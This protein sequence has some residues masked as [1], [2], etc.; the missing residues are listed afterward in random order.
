MVSWASASA[1]EDGDHVVAVEGIVDFLAKTGANFR[2]V[3][4]ADGFQQHFLEAVAFKD[5]AK[6]VEHLALERLAHDSKFFEQAEIDITLAGF[7]GDEIPEVADLLLAD[8]VDAT[9]ALFE[10]VWIPR[11]VVVHHEVGVLKVDAF[12]GSIRG[13]EDADFGVGAE[14]RLGLAAVV[15]VDTTVN[16]DDGVVAAEHTGNFLRAGNSG[17]RGAR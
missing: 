7:L 4:I 14:E 13:D 15:A 3:A 2:L 12:T 11:Q 17:C 1:V 16:D 8:A 6:N 9:E 10:A 5:F